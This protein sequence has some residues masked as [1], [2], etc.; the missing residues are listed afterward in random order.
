MNKFSEM[1]KAEKVTHQQSTP[2]SLEGSPLPVLTFQKTPSVSPFGQAWTN[3]TKN[4]QTPHPQ[5]YHT[6]SKRGIYTKLQ[7][8]SLRVENQGAALSTS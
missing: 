4:G 2:F 1:Q 8:M 5:Y 3:K 6:I 7:G